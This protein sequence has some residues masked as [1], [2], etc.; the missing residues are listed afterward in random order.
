MVAIHEWGHFLAMRL[1]G[2]EVEE[3]C[4]GF[5]PRIASKKWGKTL[6][7]IGAI[8]L[9]GFCKPQGGDLSGQSAEEMYAKP[10]QPGDYLAASW[11]R[12]ILILFAGP[13]MNFLSGFLIL[14]LVLMMGERIYTEKPLLGF[15]PPDSLAYD[16]GFKKGDVLTKVDGKPIQN[17]ATDLDGTYARFA[18]DPAATALIDLDR[19]GKNL[20]ITLKGDAHKKKFGFGLFS[21]APALIGDVP[22][23]APAWKA[24]I[25][26]GDKVLSVNGK[27]I[28]DWMELSYTIKSGNDDHLALQIERNGKDYPVSITRIFNGDDHVIGIQ[29]Q[30]AGDYQVVRMG[31]FKAVPEAA[32]RGYYFCAKYL[33]VIGK[34]VTLKMNLKDNVGGAVTIFRTLYQKASQGLE[35]F[36]KT[37]ISISFILG[38]MNLL[39]L[40]IVDGGQ[41][42][43][44][45]VEAVKRQP[46]SVKFQNAY[47]VAGFALVGCLMLYAVGMDVWNWVMENVHRQIP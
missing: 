13:A 46:L 22:L 23:G 35:E 6:W 8:P 4:I 29:A 27:K 38:L 19:R 32:L 47:Q 20:Q 14:V 28:S 39:P 9:G 37:I 3:Y 10:P 44:C 1:L 36:L 43:L 26:P 24:G 16:C 40:G 25:R 18:K 42:I 21:Y 15:V 5:P 31:F 11:W 41:I 33:D 30:Q 2:V 7:S 12:R 17:L 45:L 34:L